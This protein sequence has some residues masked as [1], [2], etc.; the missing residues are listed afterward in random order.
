MTNGWRASASTRAFIAF[1]VDIAPFSFAEEVNV[2]AT[3]SAVCSDC[4]D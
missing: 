1:I 2:N 3:L 4:E